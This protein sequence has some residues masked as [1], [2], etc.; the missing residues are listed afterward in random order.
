MLSAEAPIKAWHGQHAADC[1]SVIRAG[2]ICTEADAIVRNRIEQ[3][4]MR[5]VTQASVLP[6]LLVAIAVPTSGVAEEPVDYRTQIAPVIAKQCAACH[7]RDEQESGLRLDSA[8][9]TLRGGDRGPAIVAGK[10]G[11]SIFY[12]ALLGDDDVPRMPLD[13]PPLPQETIDLI[14][15]WIDEGAAMPDDPAVEEQSTHSDHWSFQPVR[16]PAAPMVKDRSW[17]RTPIDNFI[18]ARLE[19]E[20]VAPSPQADRRT[21]LR[22]LSLD[23]LGLPPTIEEI[24]RFLDDEQSGAYERLVDRL[25]A[26]PHFGERW[27]RHW[28]DVARYAD[29]NGFTIDGPRSIWM[30]RDWVIDAFNSDMPFD[31]FV[32]EQLAGDLLPD[33]THE[34]L[35]ATGFHRNT[36]I[37]EEGGT[38]DEQ[39]RVDAV[40]DRV[41]TT[42]T[43]F[44][45]LTL[46]CARCHRHKYDPIT[47]RE[48]YDL[49]AIFN[50]CDEPKLSLPTDV[51]ST[52]LRELKGEIV[53][54]TAA[55]AELRENAEARQ[56]HEQ[57]LAK[58]KKSQKSLL[59]AIPTTMILRKRKE[60]RTSYVH[61]RGD[62][63][64][65]GA[66]VSGGV[67]AVL[68]DLGDDEPNPS[69]L[70]FARWLMDPEN[71]LTARV[72]VNRFWQQL[73]GAGLVRTENDF[74]VQGAP[75][76]HPDLLDWLSSEFIRGD[77]GVKAIVRLIVTS[78]TYRQSSAAPDELIA[79]DADNRLLARQSRLR[80]EAEA[81]RDVA[82]AAGGL[83]SSK[84]KGPGVYP[85][86]PEGI[87][88]LT[89]NKKNW[90]VSTGPDRFRRGMYTYFWRSSPYPLMPTFDAPDANTSC[91]RRV[92]SNTPLQA[93]MLANDRGFVEIAQGLACR[94]LQEAANYDDG[95][96]RYGFQLCLSR[97]PSAAEAERVLAFY[98]VQRSAFAADAQRAAAAAPPD[99]PDGFDVTDV[100]AWTAVSRV[101]L[102][103]DETI[104]RE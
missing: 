41:D 49:F 102:N 45:G 68:P 59:A 61:V 39:F 20:G 46:G 75:P 3:R 34:Q 37:N 100:A 60:P 82:L 13:E 81:V 18:L 16:R 56:P 79:W 8:Q 42:G 88:V 19:R 83:L 50:N 10:S 52:R 25:L 31:R 65:K 47:Q 5:Q 36:L 80:L 55:I 62:F 104:T 72:T 32:T 35:I 64:R 30:Y 1:Q 6:A 4:A 51:Q 91:T 77:W 103:L 71:P 69:R 86:Q 7:G 44:L 66:V 53:A 27:G 11:E 43:V 92:R 78:S 14:K 67:P 90:K 84:L 76:T 93:L 21:L 85:P 96:L 26:S 99:I 40:A 28:L 22:R 12:L 15:R 73:F 54:T 87:Y 89:Q 24:D 95:R 98:E 48:Y 57:K 97:E 101:L 63:L 29:S 33:A 58:L 9:A 2:N 17:V 23:L 74:G 70:D 94:I 38:D